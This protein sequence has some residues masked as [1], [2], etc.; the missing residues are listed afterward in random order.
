MIVEVNKVHNERSEIV[1]P[2]YPD[3]FFDSCIGDP[4]WKIQFM[5]KHWD[6]ELPSIELW[7]EVF[8][9]LKP[10]A[11]MFI[12][13]GTRTQHRMACNIED[14]GFEIRDVITHHY[15]S[16]FPKS[17]NIGDGIGTALKPAT[18]FWT[19]ARKPITEK[20]ISENVFKWQTGG[21]RI[22]DS[23][24]PFKSEADKDSATYGTGIDFKG[25]NF[26]GK[27]AK[28]T[29]DKN[30]EA[31]PKGRWPA[32]LILDEFTSKMIDLQAPDAGAYAPVQPGDRIHGKVYNKYKSQGNNSE[33]VFYG[34]SGGASRF[35]Y[36]AKPDGS[37]KDKG[38]EDFY[39]QK[40]DSGFERIT[41]HEW[42]LLEERNRATGNIHVTVKPVDLMRWL[43]KLI[44]HKGGICLD[45]FCGSG[46][47]LIGCKMELI[48][49]VGIDMEANHVMISEARVAAWN[50]PKF[51]EQTLF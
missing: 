51:I 37:E 39:W 1:L 43:V 48:N 49:Y 9:V 20:T 3:N 36:C 15:G 18:E 46:T 35:Y 4:P 5:N 25:G 10:G 13:C 24:I 31:N 7:K 32:N 33:D 44:T 17:L 14:A 21:L 22:D 11:H 27:D 19:L 38:L 41:L 45:P 30:I 28:K 29:E 2:Q 12:C 42:Q 6:Y 8:R 50:A 40:T 26:G 16:G 34:D 47:T 23:R